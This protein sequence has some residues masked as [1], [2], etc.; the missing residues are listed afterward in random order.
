MGAGV[1]EVNRLRVKIKELEDI[2]SKYSKE[3]N[4][5]NNYDS[6]TGLPNHVLFYDRIKYAI[7]HARRYKHNLAVLTLD[8]DFFRRI[9][10]ELGRGGGDLLLRELANRLGRILRD[11]DSVALFHKASSATDPI[12]SRLSA[13]EFGVLLTD[14]GDRQSVTWVVDRIFKV[15][16]K[17]ITINDQQIVVTS[18]I[19]IS[20]YPE[21]GD[22]ADSLLNHAV[23]ARK[24]AK[25]MSGENNY[26]I[27]DSKLHEVSRAQTHIEQELKRA[28]ENAE[29]VLFYQPK[30]DIAS[31]RISGVEA[32]IRWNHPE[33]GILSPFEF[34]SVAEKSGLIV[35]I[36]ECVI[37][38][39][40]LQIKQWNNLGIDNVRV[41]V[42][43]STIQLRQ[44]NFSDQILM[45]VKDVGVS[46][47]CLELEITETVIMD[48]LDTAVDTLNYLHNK[49][50]W[51][52]IDDFGTGYSSLSYL[53]HLPLDTLK[54]DR[55]FL[56][57]LITDNYDR[58]I[59]KTIIAMAHSMNLKVIAEGVET[60][61]Q[62]ALLRQYSCDEMQGY[63]FS[64][65][66]P[67][68]EATQ[69]LQTKTR[70]QLEC[71]S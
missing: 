39:A 25:K 63:L 10:N 57:D 2:A 33:K 1:D 67:A 24:N 30:L 27:F 16:S 51:I 3:I 12:V 5:R 64:R 47:D 60:R 53:K 71:V 50:F 38:Q 70:S 34:I 29:F 45:I 65:P 48:N 20:V 4:F 18:N 58:T 15:L 17:P 44:K 23:V 21:D 68:E 26:L 56:K 31:S 7:T 62:L 59:V 54:I 11:S 55:S 46:P 9:N 42:N 13:D 61:E 28:I 35:Q 14:L 22:S 40:C 19:G 49:G 37:R 69:L 52:S 43:L 41:A 32:L 66:V 6:L 36:G 8:I